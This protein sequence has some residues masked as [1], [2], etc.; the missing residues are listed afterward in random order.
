[1]RATLP[2]RYTVDFLTETTAFWRPKSI[3]ICSNP[4]CSGH[5]HEANVGDVLRQAA[6]A[7][8]TG[9]SRRLSR[10]ELLQTAVL[11]LGGSVHSVSP[12]LNEKGE[13]LI[14]LEVAVLER[15]TALRSAS[16]SY[17]E[18]I[19]RVVEIETKGR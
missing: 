10:K 2:P 11:D 18:V 15:L 6:A 17:S 8:L 3:Q 16:K 19:L 12:K 4:Q 7:G 14:W 13:R 9:A 5:I 1:M